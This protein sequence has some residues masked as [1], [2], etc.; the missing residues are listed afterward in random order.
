VLP[1]DIVIPE[2]PPF[3]PA[4]RK[5]KITRRDVLRLRRKRKAVLVGGGKNQ[6]RGKLAAMFHGMTIHFPLFDN[7]A[8]RKEATTRKERSNEELKGGTWRGVTGEKTT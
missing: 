8:D 2:G 6:S 7:R 4:S 3:R 5:E 1:H